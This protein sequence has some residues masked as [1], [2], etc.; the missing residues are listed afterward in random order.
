MG[1]LY[2]ESSNSISR[3]ISPFEVVLLIVGISVVIVGGYSIHK[4]YLFDGYLSWNLLQVIFLWLILLVLLILAAIL[5]NV[6]EELLIITREH[7]TE[8]KL[9]REET[10]ALKDCIK[11]KR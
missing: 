1:F 10:Q 8:T 6:K 5:E 3:R 2:T 11:R 7:I 4:Q 9:I